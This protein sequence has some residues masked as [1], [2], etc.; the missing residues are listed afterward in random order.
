MLRGDA[1]ITSTLR[2]GGVGGKTKMRCYWT[3]VAFA[4]C[5]DVGTRQWAPHPTSPGPLPAIRSAQRVK[6]SSNFFVYI[7]ICFAPPT[8]VPK[9]STH[10]F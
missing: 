8:R 7:L 4:R 9:F 10:K 5:T 2:G 3:Y 1:H 6:I